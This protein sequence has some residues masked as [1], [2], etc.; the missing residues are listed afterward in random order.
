M[1]EFPKG[2]ALVVGGSGGI[3]NDY[4]ARKGGLLI[5]SGDCECGSRV[6]LY[7]DWSRFC[8]LKHQRTGAPSE[9]G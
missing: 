2:V 6:G 3:G 7:A 8:R 5:C 1:D 4:P 9:Q